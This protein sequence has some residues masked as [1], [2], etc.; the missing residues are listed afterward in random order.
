PVRPVM[1]LGLRLVAV[2]EPLAF[3]RTHAEL[4]VVIEQRVEVHR[5]VL[6]LRGRAHVGHTGL[7]LPGDRLGTVQVTAERVDRAVRT[8][9]VVG[10]V[11][12]HDL[13]E[14]GARVLD[15][16]T[17]LQVHHPGAARPGVAIVRGTRYR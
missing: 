11:V 4:D 3:I 12:A 17:G 10:A 5:T 1:R 15:E 8:Q 13:P 16:R 9:R 2:L 14:R 6:L 7:K